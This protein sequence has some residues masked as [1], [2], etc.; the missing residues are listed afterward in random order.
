VNFLKNQV[1][2]CSD[3]Q[4]WIE[5]PITLQDGAVTFSPFVVLV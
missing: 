3:G 2:R 5:K 1:T 4:P